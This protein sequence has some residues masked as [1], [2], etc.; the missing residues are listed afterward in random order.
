MSLDKSFNAKYRKYISSFF[1][2]LFFIVS[3]FE[4]MGEY[5]EDK[6]LI[7]ITK[8][9]I[10]PFLFAYYLSLTK[11]INY[12]FLVAIIC[13]WIAN[14]LFI[15]NTIN[16]IIFGSVFF[17]VYR[18][19]VIYIVMNKVKM[20]S[21]VPLIIGSVP[22]IFIYAT[23]C[24][25]S[26]EAMGDNIYLFLIHGIFTIFLGGLS[27]GNYIMVSN[28]SNLV[29]FL[30]TMLFALT[31]FVFVLKVYYEDANFFHALAM[32]M[33]VVGQFLLTKFMFLTEENKDKYQ[34]TLLS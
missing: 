8:P 11:K 14:L 17:L 10:L 1:L 23:V 32:T 2:C 33:F 13:S 24:S 22:F 3:L 4:I 30:S 18:I 9:F 25:L 20:P 15:E 34:T 31:Q 29:L 21:L 5:K 12:F 6:L 7:W 28:K 16:W 19:L 26:F 27:L